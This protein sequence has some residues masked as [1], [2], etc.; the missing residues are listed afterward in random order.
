MGLPPRRAV[1]RGLGAAAALL[2]LGQTRTLA[3]PS[4]MPRV[5]P[6]D[7]DWPSP[8]TWEQLNRAAE[9]RLVKVDPL[10]AACREQP[11]SGACEALLPNLRNPYFLGEQPAGTESSG[12]I[13]AWQSSPS[14]YAIPAQSAADV[15]AAVNFVVH[16]DCAW[17]SKAAATPTSA[18][19]TRR[20]RC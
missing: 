5:R 14:A 20:I 13:D 4:S 16:T 10:L 17:S 8:A 11:G 19:Q 7:P 1:L 6:G 18:G 15:V 9:G 3:A 2:P 12:W